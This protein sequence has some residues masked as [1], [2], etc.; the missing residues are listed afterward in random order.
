MKPNYYEKINLASLE[1]I[2]HKLAPENQID[3]TDIIDYFKVEAKLGNIKFIQQLG[4]RFL[5]GQGIKQD[6]A[7]ALY[8]FEKGMKLNDPTCMFYLGELYLNGWGVEKVIKL[9]GYI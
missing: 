9:F 4:Q 3:I 2:G 8:F 7:Q 5:Y 1:Y 6:F